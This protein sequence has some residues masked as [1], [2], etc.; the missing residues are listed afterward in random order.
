[1]SSCV[2]NMNMNRSVECLFKFFKFKF[3]VF[4]V[5]YCFLEKLINILYK[6]AEIKK[7]PKIS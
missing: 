2:L 7:I 1:M 3:Q 4:I 6:N 5:L